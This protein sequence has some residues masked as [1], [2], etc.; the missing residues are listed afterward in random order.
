MSQVFGEGG[1]SGRLG[2]CPKFS[3]FSIWQPSLRY[4]ARTRPTCNQCDESF[5]DKSMLGAHTKSTHKKRPVIGPANL[6]NFPL[7]EDLPLMD[8]SEELE[9]IELELE[10]ECSVVSYKCGKCHCAFGSDEDLQTHCD[11]EHADLSPTEININL[12]TERKEVNSGLVCTE[13]VFEAKDL[14][15]F[16]FHRESHVLREGFNKKKH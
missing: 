7:V 4:K 12:P 6:S 13:C 3:R 11:V 5:I 9:H 1:R 15:D 16:N 2:Q 10:E 8:V 14:A